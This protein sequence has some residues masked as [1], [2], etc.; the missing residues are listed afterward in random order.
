MVPCM[1]AWKWPGSRHSMVYVPVSSLM[2][3]RSIDWPAA[4]S[5]VLRLRPSR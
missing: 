5:R 2:T 4:A 1:P 3:S